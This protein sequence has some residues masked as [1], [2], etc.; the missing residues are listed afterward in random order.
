MFQAEKYTGDRKEG[1]ELV[2]KQLLRPYPIW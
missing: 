1:Y 2:V